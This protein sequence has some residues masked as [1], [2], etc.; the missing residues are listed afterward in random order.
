VR[1]RIKENN[2]TVLGGEFLHM[3]CAAH[4]LNLVVNDGLKELDDSICNVR[5]AV[6]FIRSLLA[7]MAMFK[8]CIENLD[9]QNKKVVCLDVLARWNSTSLMLSIAEK[10]QRAFEV[11]KMLKVPGF[12]D[13][14]NV[15]HL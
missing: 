4:I 5:N 9:I 6:R 8:R 11:L 13:W 15:R 7:R 1:M 14:E 2:S 3:W 10:Y 12:L